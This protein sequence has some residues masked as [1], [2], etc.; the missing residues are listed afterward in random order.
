MGTKYVIICVPALGTLCNSYMM[1]QNF[2]LNFSSL[3]NSQAAI[4][5]EIYK[6][7]CKVGAYAI[8]SATRKRNKMRKPKEIEEFTMIS[9]QEDESENLA[10][11]AKQTRTAF[12]DSIQLLSENIQKGE[13]ATLALLPGQGGDVQENLTKEELHLHVCRELYDLKRVSSISG[14]VGSASYTV[15]SKSYDE[16]IHCSFDDPEAQRQDQVDGNDDYVGTITNEAYVSHR[17]VPLLRSLK[18]SARSLASIHSRLQFALFCTGALATVCAAMDLKALVPIAVACGSTINTVMQHFNLKMRLMATNSAI[19]SLQNV[20]TFWNSLGIVDRRV[21]SSRERIVRITEE[22][23]MQ[24]AIAA[25]GVL[26][27][28]KTSKSKRKESQKEE[29]DDE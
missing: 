8:N 4:V 21:Q 2:H 10:A 9:G 3:N 17:V 16:T 18:G 29:S 27:P 28:V 1:S 7:R 24:V 11:A 15:L 20:L 14:S 12:S 23:A 25:S 13:L 5:S 19:A 6:F 22:A 26:P